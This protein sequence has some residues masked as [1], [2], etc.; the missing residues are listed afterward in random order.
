MVPTK[1]GLKP[2]IGD[3]SLVILATGLTLYA[4]V[5]RIHVPPILA[6]VCLEAGIDADACSG[7]DRS[8]A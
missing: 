6:P 5:I 2:T 3:V 8:T 7:Q 4:L 1:I